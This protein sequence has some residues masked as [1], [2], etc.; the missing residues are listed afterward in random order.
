MPRIPDFTS[1]A[2]TQDAPSLTA[3]QTPG[4]EAFGGGQALTDLKANVS[5]LGETEKQFSEQKKQADNT[6]VMSAYDTLTQAKNNLIFDPQ[7]GAMTK[8]GQDAATVTSDY[9]AQFAKAA[10]QLQAN[11]SNDD[12]RAM[13]AR[14]RQKVEGELNLTLEKHTFQET[15]RYNK[16]VVDSSLKTTQDD[17]TLNY[18]QPGKIDQ[19]VQTVR[20]LAAKQAQSEGITDPSLVE[21][22][23]KQAQSKVYAGVLERM[24]STD[25]PG[26][27]G[28]YAAIQGQMTADDRA[29]IDKTLK[30]ST[31]AME[32]QTKADA[33]MREHQDLPS[34]LG[35]AREMEPGDLR[36]KTIQAIKDR[37]ADD[38]TAKRDFD[39]T[40]FDQASD[41]VEQSKGQ[42]MPPVTLLGG[43]SSDLRA[44]L[45]DR[46]RQLRAGVT[47][48]QAGPKYIALM[49]MAANEPQ[50]FKALNLNEVRGQ[51][52]PAELT[53]F[54]GMQTDL[55]SGKSNQALTVHRSAQTIAA[56]TADAIGLKGDPEAR[57][58]FTDQFIAR[59]NQRQELNGGKPLSDEQMTS[60]ADRM[61]M[62]AVKGFFGGVSKRRYQL[63][64]D[65]LKAAPALTDVSDI[66]PEQ[67]RQIREALARSGQ[68]YSDDK[69]LYYMNRFLGAQN[70]K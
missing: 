52:T 47:A 68:A 43:M 44:K 23:Q 12:Q 59:V 10:D 11:L 25:D 4:I 41:I 22:R 38:E 21:E 54:V 34:A 15:E 19:S 17:A 26:A 42:T 33:I 24:M 3:P 46:A 2:Q 7:S 28:F 27:R 67:L 1:Q 53:H 57:K 45:E 49:N 55:Q 65:D 31:I 48:D 39:R 66:P 13:F 18:Y 60:E 36:T 70:G 62:P 63:S 51:V 50:K 37:H 32:S 20:G 30:S 40:R 64:P 16:E 29:S 6:R 35:A 58:V 14:V 69:A 61:V 56:Q 8:K 5:Q 9:G